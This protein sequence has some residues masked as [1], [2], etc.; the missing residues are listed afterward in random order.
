VQVALG[1]PLQHL[2]AEIFRQR[3]VQEGLPV[4]PADH[5]AAVA[6]HG[7]FPAEAELL[8]VLDGGLVAPARG[9]DEAHP[10]FAQALHGGQGAGRDLE[11]PAQQRAVQVEG[12]EVEAQ[13]AF[14]SATKGLPS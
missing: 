7:V 13:P 14:R 4:H 12:A 2:Q 3:A 5:G 9:D 6:D 1:G 8:G 10:A 11:V